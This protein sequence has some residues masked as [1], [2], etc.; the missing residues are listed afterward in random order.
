MAFEALLAL[1]SRA[2]LGD[3][4]AKCV[5]LDGLIVWPLLGDGEKFVTFCRCFVE[6]VTLD[7]L[8]GTYNEVLVSFLV[9][10]CVLTFAMVSK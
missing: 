8:P 10:F 3:G 6:F 1:L 9:T 5:A 7:S 4:A 2:L